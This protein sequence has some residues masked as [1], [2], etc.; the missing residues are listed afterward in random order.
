[1]EKLLPG[2][3]L[4]KDRKVCTCSSSKLVTT[5]IHIVPEIESG[6]ITPENRTSILYFGP[7]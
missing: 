6:E 3:I 5:V 2:V 7:Y 1:M 4:R